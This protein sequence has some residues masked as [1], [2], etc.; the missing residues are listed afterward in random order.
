MIASGDRKFKEIWYLEGIFLEA[1]RSKRIENFI[2]CSAKV[3]SYEMEKNGLRDFPAVSILPVL[4]K[5]GR[6]RSRGTFQSQSK[7]E[8]LKNLPEPP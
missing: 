7:K 6:G 1:S 2:F 8:E 4:A 5:R 3:S